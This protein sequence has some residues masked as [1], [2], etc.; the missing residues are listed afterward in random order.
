MPWPMKFVNHDLGLV[1]SASDLALPLELLV[2]LIGPRF[3][4]SFVIYC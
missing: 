2:L 1:S 3:T 4:N